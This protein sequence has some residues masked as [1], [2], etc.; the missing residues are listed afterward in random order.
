MKKL[1]ALSLVAM[2][3]L[4]IEVPAKAQDAQPQN[5]F[6]INLLSPLVRSG[7]IFYERAVS[8]D[9]SLLLGFFYMGWSP[10]E[11]KLRGFGITPEL[12]YYLSEKYP[13]P[14][15]A[16][17]APF[18]RY[19][20]ITGTR[21]GFEGKGTLSAFGGGL[22]IGT[23]TMFKNKISLD[24]WAG[25]AYYSGTQKYT[26]ETDEESIEFPGF[27]GFLVRFGITVGIGF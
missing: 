6:K 27:D 4:L 10:G 25:P 23:Q 21:E 2:M 26:G 8:E 14:R 5:L 20:N 3:L 22:L 7:S 16:F 1:F 9:I 17:I 18:I 19:Q 12:R 11:A 15:G 24:A 13:A